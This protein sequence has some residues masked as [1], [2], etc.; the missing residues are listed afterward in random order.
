MANINQ[1]AKAVTRI[2]EETE[3]GNGLLHAMIYDSKERPMARDFSEMAHELSIASREFR[4]IVERI[5]RG[6]GT[7]GALISD[8][9]VYDDIRRLFGRLERNKLLRHII[10]SRL[11]DRDF[12]KDS[13]P[14]EGR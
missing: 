7:V 9:A 8:P 11:R 5:N 1:A 3:K 14:A 2:V 12:E 13:S 10:R 6:E 4:E